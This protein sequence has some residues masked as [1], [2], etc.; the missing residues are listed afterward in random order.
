[1]PTVASEDDWQRKKWRNSE[2]KSVKTS[3]VGASDCDSDCQCESD[4]RINCDEFPE[5]AE[6][7]FA[8]KNSTSEVHQK[9]RHEA[10]AQRD[11]E[12]LIAIVN[13]TA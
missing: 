4:H 11:G 6:S 2:T 1:M 10:D 12:E 13:L 9:E 5:S 7:T 3:F 8:C